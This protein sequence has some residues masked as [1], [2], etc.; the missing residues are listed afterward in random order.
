MRVLETQSYSGG[1]LIKSMQITKI[2]LRKNS[3]YIMI[4][5]CK[6]KKNISSFKLEAVEIRSSFFFDVTTYLNSA[7]VFISDE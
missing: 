7:H 3:N 4:N 2:S 1:A 6:K 5:I